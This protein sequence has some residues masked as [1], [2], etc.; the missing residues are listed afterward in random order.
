MESTCARGIL[1]RQRSH[2]RAIVYGMPDTESGV[3]TTA[4]HFS[5]LPALQIQT[6]SEGSKGNGRS[7]RLGSQRPPLQPMAS[8]SKANRDKCLMKWRNRRDM[9]SLSRCLTH[10]ESAPLTAT[11]ESTQTR[12]PQQGAALMK[13]TS[14][15]VAWDVHRATT[16][17]SVR[18]ESGRVIAR[19]VLPTD[20]AVITEFVR[21]MRGAVHVALEEGTQA[22]WL[23][24]LLAP[25]VDRV[26]VCDRRGAP[27][28][29]NKADQVDADQ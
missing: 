26:V 19:S 23:H 24:D 15:Y 14:K 8:R 7:I 9:A 1:R 21:G 6:T 4:C 18:E 20:S 28:Q 17:A 22:Q 16:S 25:L 2:S 12:G 29:G 5:T 11:M 10:V 3:M 13:R 27:R